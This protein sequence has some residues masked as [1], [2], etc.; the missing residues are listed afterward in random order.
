MNKRTDG[1]NSSTPGICQHHFHVRMFPKIKRF[2]LAVTT[3]RA[4]TRIAENAG[5][6]VQAASTTAER[7]TVPELLPPRAAAN[8]HHHAYRFQLHHCSSN[9][10]VQAGTVSTVQSTLY[11]A[12]TDVRCMATPDHDT[13][14]MKHARHDYTLTAQSPGHTWTSLRNRFGLS[15]GGYLFTSEWW[16]CDVR[17]S[18]YS[19]G[20]QKSFMSVMSHPR[21]NMPLIAS[22]T[23]SMFAGRGGVACTCA[24]AR[25]APAAETA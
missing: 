20:S 8:L 24:A 1:A 14:V 7:V 16:C 21:L 25:G 23:D 11:Q 17:M 4:R 12:D 22:F 6:S 9:R 2:I 18:M 3:T 5:G 19:W 10:P 15:S 13:M